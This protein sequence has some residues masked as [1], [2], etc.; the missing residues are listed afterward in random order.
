MTQR[1]ARP[2]K[3]AAFISIIISMAVIIGACQGAVGPKAGDKGDP[4]D[5]GDARY[6]PGRQGLRASPRSR[7]MGAVP[8]VLINGHRR[9]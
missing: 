6:D 3:F 1:V 9:D 2:M 5:P 8:F 7:L 4:G